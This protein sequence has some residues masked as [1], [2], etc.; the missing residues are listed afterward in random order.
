M[1]R[2]G[3]MFQPTRA[4]RRWHRHVN[5]KQRRF[6]VSSALAASA[7]HFSFFLFLSPFSFFQQRH[8]ADEVC[9]VGS[10]IGYGTWTQD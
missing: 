2:G 4:W 8:K 5:R 3:R 1:C 7:V 10:S 9:F 6:A